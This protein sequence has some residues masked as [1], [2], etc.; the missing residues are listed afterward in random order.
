MILSGENGNTQSKTC[1]RYT[2][3]TT[4]MM[5]SDQGLNLDMYGE[6]LLIKCWAAAQLQWMGA[7]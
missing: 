1:S 3:S 4:T 6:R 2:T 7:V 5:W